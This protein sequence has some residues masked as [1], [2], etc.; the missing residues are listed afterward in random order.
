MRLRHWAAVV[1]SLTTLA[2][3]QLATSGAACTSGTSGLAPTPDMLP[4][5]AN[6]AMGQLQT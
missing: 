3:Q 4:I 2:D 6:V 1:A 5:A